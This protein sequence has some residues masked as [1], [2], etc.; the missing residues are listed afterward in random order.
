M[1]AK[2]SFCSRRS[3]FVTLILVAGA[4]TIAAV[5]HVSAATLTWQ[6]ASGDWMNS[7]NWG[8]ALPTSSDT[9]LIASGTA[10]IAAV[11]P[12]CSTVTIDGGG[13]AGMLLTTAGSL[14]VGSSLNCGQSTTGAFT[15]SGGTCSGGGNLYLGSNAG[16]SGSY[17]LS[18]GALTLQGGQYVGSGTICRKF[19]RSQG[20][21]E[22]DPT[23]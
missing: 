2:L 22:V 17:T 16:S 18:A 21:S 14:N 6:V 19:F 23:H 4:I 10:T 5:S 12:T 8:G 11:G 3:F 15:Q 13:V 9:A 7:A 20:K 1:H